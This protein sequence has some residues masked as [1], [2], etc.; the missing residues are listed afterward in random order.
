[1]PSAETWAYDLW[2]LAWDVCAN[3][4]VVRGG[5]RA[6]VERWRCMLANWVG[7]CRW[8]V[9]L[10][11]W[12]GFTAEIVVQLLGSVA[13]FWGLCSDYKEPPSLWH[14]LKSPR[15]LQPCWSPQ[16]PE[17][18]YAEVGLWAM[19]S[20][21][22]SLITFPH[23]RLEEVS[24]DTELCCLAGGMSW[25]SWNLFYPLQCVYSQKV[26]SNMVLQSLYC[27]SKFS[28][29]ICPSMEGCQNPYFFGGV[30]PK[31][32]LQTHPAWYSRCHKLVLCRLHQIH[33]SGVLLHQLSGNK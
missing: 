22:Y 13:G 30:W 23:E 28:T 29:N 11:L 6:P 14:D 15:T 21:T 26:C 2:K 17:R 1:M 7:G 8:A 4:H 33:N 20:T 9:L 24:L 16:G 27:T 18:G 3:V 10:D 12:V 5:L 31:C 25:L 19:L 32:S